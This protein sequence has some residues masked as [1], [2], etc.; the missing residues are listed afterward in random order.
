MCGLKLRDL[1]FFVIGTCQAAFIFLVVLFTG[2]FHNL[3]CPSGLIPYTKLA[4]HSAHPR[5]DP[6]IYLSAPNASSVVLPT[7]YAQHPNITVVAGPWKQTRKTRK[8][9]LT[10]ITT[11]LKDSGGV[12]IE[13]G[14]LNYTGSWPAPASVW[15][16]ETGPR[17]MGMV[18][19]VFSEPRRLAMATNTKKT[20]NGSFTRV[21]FGAV[22]GWKPLT[23]EDCPV[24]E[25][26]DEGVVRTS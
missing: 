13:V 4:N 20:E 18:H 15:H 9:E 14:T 10:E 24:G 7:V 22:G 23:L 26:G 6:T 8:A 19:V 1:L 2:G 21:C 5:M 3:N 11:I 25:E 16:V 12:A 17:Y